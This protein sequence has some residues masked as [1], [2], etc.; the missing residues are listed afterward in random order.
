MQELMPSALI[1]SPHPKLPASLFSIL[2][3][4][5]NCYYFI[6]NK[7]VAT[8]KKIKAV[9]HKMLESCGTLDILAEAYSQLESCSH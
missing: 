4:Y 5:C 8:L 9:P 1:W 7:H 3:Q 2:F 6:P